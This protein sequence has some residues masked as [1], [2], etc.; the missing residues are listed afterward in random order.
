MH[1]FEE[2][3]DVGAA[4]TIVFGGRAKEA[5][6]QLA[7]P[8]A[9]QQVF[10]A[11]DSRKEGEVR[12]RRGIERTRRAPVAIPH[13]LHEALEGAIGGRRIIDDGEGIEGAVIGGCGDGGMTP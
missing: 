13:R 8:E 4:P 11:E 1:A 5:T 6:A 7:V 2:A 3:G 9:L 12:G 10:A